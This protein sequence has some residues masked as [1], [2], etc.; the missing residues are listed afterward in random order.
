MPVLSD[1]MIISAFAAL[2]G[3]VVILAILLW[4]LERTVERF[5]HGGKAENLDDVL[6][7]LRTEAMTARKNITALEGRLQHAE[8]RLQRS[9]QHKGMVRFNPFKDVGGD[10]SFSLA[11]LDEAGDGVVISSLYARDGVRVYGKPVTAGA[12]AYQLS[13]EEHKAIAGSAHR[14]P[15]TPHNV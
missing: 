9:V 6:A 11:L 7:L 13:E 14:A 4:R 1:T 10:Q 3:L 8:Q 2:L 15:A 12:S 5:T